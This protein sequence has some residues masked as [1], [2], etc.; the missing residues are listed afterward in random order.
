MPRTWKA[1]P[2]RLEQDSPGQRPGIPQTYRPQALKGRCTRRADLLFRPF[3]ALTPITLLCPRAL[4]WAILLRPFGAGRP[5]AS[6]P[7]WRPALLLVAVMYVQIV[8]GALMRHKEMPLGTRAHILLAFVVVA[9]AAWFGVRVL[10]TQPPGSLA[11]RAIWILWLLLAMQ[12]MLGLETMLSK[13]DVR[14]GYNTGGV[15]APLVQAPELVRSLHYLVGA[16]TF[17]AA[18]V[19][20]LIARR[21]V[22]KTPRP[23]VVPRRQLE[24]AL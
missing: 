14:W 12:L 4:P 24:G 11:R 3:R 9:V 17:A 23:M 13:F 21:Q 20:A 1:E 15:L 22:A 18:V 6:S 10:Q 8:F 16:A 2:E 19:N 7:T 5:L